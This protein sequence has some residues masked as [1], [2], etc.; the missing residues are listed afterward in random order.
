MSRL[1]IQLVGLLAIL[2]TIAVTV[3]P[4]RAQVAQAE[5]RGTVLDQSG[6]ALPGV[7]ISAT[8]VETGTARTT[9]TSPAGTYVMPALPIGS[10]TVRAELAG[11]RRSQRKAS[12]WGSASR[13][14]W[15]SRSSWRRSPKQSRCRASRR[16]STRRNPSSPEKSRRDRSRDCRSTAAT[17]WASSR[18]S[19]ARAVIKARSRWERPAATWPSTRS[20]AST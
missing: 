14:R 20:T 11:L 13:D 4:A 5:L 7:T 15:T 1:R 6:A 9:V 19:P 10:Y 2:S 3:L 18:S 12:G 16:S 8:H 17:G